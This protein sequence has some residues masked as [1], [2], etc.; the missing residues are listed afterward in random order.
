MNWYTSCTGRPVPMSLEWMICATLRD[1]SHLPPFEE[2]HGECSAGCVKKQITRTPSNQDVTTYMSGSLEG[3]FGR[4]R[5]DFASHWTHAHNTMLRL[6]KHIGCCWTW[7]EEHLE[8][9]VLVPQVKNTECTIITPRA[10]TMLERTLKDAICCQYVENLK[11]KPDQGKA[12][13]VTCKWDTSNHFLPRGSFTRFVDWKFIDRARLNCILLNGAIRHRNRDKRCRRCGYTNETLPHVLCS[14][15]PHSRAWQPRHNAIHDRLARAIPPPMGKVA[16]NSAIT[17]TN[18]QLR[19]DIVITNEDRKKISMVDFT[20]PFKNRTP[21]FHDA[22]AQKV[23]KYGPLAKTLR[24]KGYRV[25]KH[26]LI[27][28]A[29]GAWDSSNEQVVS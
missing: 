27:I 3:E 24:A 1:H 14:C 8:L 21:A 17:G 25:Q 28:G 13:E 4:D 29:L 7:C 6:E 23:E 22:R 26:A 16:M 20:M 12:F 11:R 2:H 15:K 9:G 19:P 5:G 10:R 18:S